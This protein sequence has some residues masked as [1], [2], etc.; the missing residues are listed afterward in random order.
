M[1][2]LAIIMAAAGCISSEDDANDQEA[3]YSDI[4]VDLID[5]DIGTLPI[6]GISEAEISGILYMREE[7]KL[8]R[9]VYLALYDLWGKPIFSNIAA[10]EETHT[11][12]VQTLIQRYGLEDPY[13]GERGA[14]TNGVLQAIYTD[15]VAAGSKSLVDALTVGAMIEELDMVD[16]AAYAESA[17][18]ADITLVYENLMMGSRNHLRSFVSQLENEGVEYEPSYLSPDAYQAIIVSG[19]ESNG[20]VTP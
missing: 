14:F 20:Y 3:G 10:S 13:I 18:N 8:A 19:M 7:E 5:K 2:L 15:L 17:D 11:S 1:V 9:D 6:E 12:A 4:D 16:I